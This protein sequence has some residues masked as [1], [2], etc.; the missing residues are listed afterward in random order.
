MNAFTSALEMNGI[1]VPLAAPAVG[2]IH[3]ALTFRVDLDEDFAGRLDFTGSRQ[4]RESLERDA[5]CAAPKGAHAPQERG[6]AGRK[7]EGKN[8]RERLGHGDSSALIFAGRCLKA[9]RLDAGLPVLRRAA[10]QSSSGPDSGGLGRLE[11]G[12]P[13]VARSQSATSGPSVTST[14]TMMMSAIFIR[15]AGT[16]VSRRQVEA[17]KANHNDEFDLYI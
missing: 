9:I 3:D 12:L 10:G 17:S 2:R 16:G 5:E 11:G 4:G 8:D 1:L 7:G 6:D 15:P 13:K 14:K